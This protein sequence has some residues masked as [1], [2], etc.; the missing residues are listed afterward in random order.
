[1][2]IFCTYCSW[3]KLKT[4]KDLPAIKRYKSRRIK[5]V[6]ESAKVLRLPFYILSG[7]FGLIPEEKPIPYYDHLLILNEIVQLSKTVRS[8]I[9]ENN[10][11]KIIFFINSYFQDE[12]ISLAYASFRS[13]CHRIAFTR[14]AWAG[15][16]GYVKNEIKGLY[17]RLVDNELFWYSYYWLG[18]AVIVVY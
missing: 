8:Q 3:P 9:E 1:M 7:E 2:E 5:S 16:D 10:I 13:N 14:W 15:F 4:K 17:S 11:N 6:S 18:C 12:N